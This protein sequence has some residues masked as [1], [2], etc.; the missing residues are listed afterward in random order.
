MSKIV[1]VGTLA[2]ATLALS[3]CSVET[4]HYSSALELRSAA[5]NA[6]LHC[7]NYVPNAHPA[8]A[9]SAGDCVGGTPAS[10]YVFDDDAVAKQQIKIAKTKL[11]GAHTKM[12]SGPNWYLL[13]ADPGAVQSEV[14]GSISK[15]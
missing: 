8:P 1:I 7:T 10:F 12:L 6:G 14:G 2:A 3:G 11:V 15:G 5:V 9:T 13:T 4:H